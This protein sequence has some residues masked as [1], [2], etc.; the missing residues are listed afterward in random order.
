MIVEELGAEEVVGVRLLGVIN[1]SFPV[2]A[3]VL[4][5]SNFAGYDT[6]DDRGM[7]V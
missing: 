5:M 2:S 3:F 1:R 4:R 7:Q 6:L